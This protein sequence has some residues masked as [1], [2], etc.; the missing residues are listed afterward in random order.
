MSKEDSTSSYADKRY[1]GSPQTILHICLRQGRN[2]NEFRNKK[3]KSFFPWLFGDV[4]ICLMRTVL[5]YI[6]SCF[7]AYPLLTSVPPVNGTHV[8]EKNHQSKKK[9]FLKASLSPLT[10]CHINSKKSSEGG[11]KKEKFL[12]FPWPGALPTQN[13]SLG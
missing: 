13:L 2:S 12:H 10:T 4:Q 7:T 6:I 8:S 9:C 3:S 1:P 5:A 11:N